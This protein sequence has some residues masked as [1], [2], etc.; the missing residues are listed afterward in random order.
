MDVGP[1]RGAVALC[2]ASGRRAR[3]G[4]ARPDVRAPRPLSIGPVRWSTRA[5]EVGMWRCALELVGVSTKLCS[6]EEVNGCPW[7]P[8]LVISAEGV[9]VN[10]WRMST[11]KAL[12]GW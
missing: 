2:V 3:T 10:R 1:L 12:R 4:R 7:P 11:R 9:L 5:A 8:E 6:N